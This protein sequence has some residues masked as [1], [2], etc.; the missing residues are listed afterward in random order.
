MKRLFALLIAS[1]VTVGLGAQYRNPL[2]DLDDSETVRALKQHVAALSAAELEGR[3][4]GS[5]GEKMAAQYLE[6]WLREYGIDILSSGNEFGV[7]VMSFSYDPRRNRVKILDAAGKLNR[8]YVR[9]IIRKDMVHVMNALQMSETT[10]VNEKRRIRYTFT[11]L[12]SQE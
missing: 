5:E 9:R 4:A 10:Y 11:P 12:D 6:D 8:W 2:E 7:A 3:R 1:V